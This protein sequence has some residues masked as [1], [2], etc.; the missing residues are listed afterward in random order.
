MLPA[1]AVALGASRYGREGRQV[2]HV[3]GR[4]SEQLPHAAE[5]RQGWHAARLSVYIPL[6]QRSVHTFPRSTVGEAHAAT[7]VPAA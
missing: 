5:A 2:R 4:L 1:A 3:D 6:G 7:Q